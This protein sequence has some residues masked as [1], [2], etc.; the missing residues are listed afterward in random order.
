MKTGGGG[1]QRKVGRYSKNKIEGCLELQ[2]GQ[3]TKRKKRNVDHINGRTW[4]CPKKGTK[5]TE[6][7]KEYIRSMEVKNRSIRG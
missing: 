3:V 4:G 7:R 5:I 2:R 1:F 6:S